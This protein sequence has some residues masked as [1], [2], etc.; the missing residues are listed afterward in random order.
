[1]TGDW[2]DGDWDDGEGFKVRTASK[3]NIYHPVP[4]QRQQLTHRVHQR[5]DWRGEQKG[6]RRPITQASLATLIVS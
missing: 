6:G 4:S 2:D 3:A 5:V 1:M